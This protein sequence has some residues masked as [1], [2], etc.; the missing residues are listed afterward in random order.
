MYSCE[1][2]HFSLKM[3]DFLNIEVNLTKDP[4]SYDFFKHMEGSR[5]ALVYLNFKIVRFVILIRCRA[6]TLTECSEF[7]SDDQLCQR[8]RDYLCF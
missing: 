3:E 7:I 8:L 6:F 5:L 2:C 1:N 4:P